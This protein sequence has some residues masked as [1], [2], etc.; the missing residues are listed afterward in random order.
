LLTY[1]AIRLFIM[2]VLWLVAHEHGV[3]ILQ[4]LQGRFDA[5]WYAGIAN[6]GYDSGIRHNPDGTPRPTNLAFFPL[7]PALILAVKTVTGV[8]AG[9]A[10]MFVSWVAGAAAA[11]GMFRVGEHLHSRRA[12]VIVVGLWASLPHGFVQSASYTET[13]FTALSAWTLLAV[14]R[15]QWLTAGALC[16]LAGLSRPSA[17]TLIL[18]VCVA[19]AIAVYQRRDGWRPVA[20]FAMAPLG[21]IA[22]LAWVGHRLGRIDGYLYMQKTAWGI[23]FDGG[24]YTWTSMT[25]LLWWGTRL[26]SYAVAIVIIMM[27]VYFA[28]SIIDRHPWQLIMYSA[29]SLMFV[30]G[31][32]G[33]FISK[34]RYLMVIFTVLLPVAISLAKAHTAKV[35]VVLSTLSIIAAWYACYLVLTWPWSP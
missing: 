9:W 27:L 3:S 12:G 29:A 4:H 18:V 32:A 34:G 19:A 22:F 10:G 17:N 14:L 6:H 31:A 20:A 25:R 2:G 15:R 5:A 35:I 13:L 28:M 1:E 16:L 30:I 7:F 26:G 33:S 23:T 24:N 11:W 8:S 21:Y